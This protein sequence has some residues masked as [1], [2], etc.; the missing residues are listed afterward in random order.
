MQE[1]WVQSLG[2]EDALEKEMA[3][4]SGILARRIPWTEEPGTLQSMGPQRVTHDWATEHTHTGVDWIVNPIE[5]MSLQEGG[6][7]R[8]TQ[9]EHQDGLL[10]WCTIE[11]RKAI[12]CPQIV[13]LQRAHGSFSTMV[14]DFEPSGLWNNKLLLLSATQFVALCNSQPRKLLG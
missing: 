10:E 14:L 5:V 1:M 11:P 3:A 4:H 9:G 6:R 12:D 7:I 2:L 13:K 8:Q